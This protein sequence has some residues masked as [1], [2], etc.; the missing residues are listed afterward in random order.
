MANLIS[1]VS[2]ALST[3]ATWQVAD[4]TSFLQT[5]TNTQTSSATFTSSSAFTTGVITIDAIGLYLST[6]SAA[7]SGTF[8]VRLFNATLGAAVAGTTVTVNVTDIDNATTNG[9]GWYCFKFSAP[10]LLLTATSYTVQIMSSTSS[11]VTM[12]RDATANN[13]CRFL[14]T[15]TTQVPAAADNLLVMGNYTGA[16]T[17]SSIVVT[18]D[19]TA[20][21]FYG[22]VEI[23][24]NGTLSSAVVASTAYTLKPAGNILVWSNGTLNLGTSGSPMPASSSLTV[25]FQCTS[26]VQFGL[27]INSGGI[28]NSFGAAM[29][30]DRAK[31]AV[32]SIVGATSL[33]LNTATNWKNG[34]LL[35][36]AST[37]VTIAQSEWGTMGADASGTSI[38][39]ITVTGGGGFAFAH[40]GTGAIAAEVINLS[41][42]IKIKG[43]APLLIDSA[44][45]NILN[46]A[47]V[48]VQWTEFLILGSA[49]TLKTGIDVGTTTGSCVFSNCSIHHSNNASSMGIRINAAAGNNITITNNVFFSI[50]A[51]HIQNQATATTGLAQIISGNIAMLNGTGAIFSISNC[52]ITLQN[53]TAV[54]ATSN[55]FTLSDLT[56]D[57][58]GV[59][60][61]N[62]AHSNGTL[63]VSLINLVAISG[64]PADGFGTFTVWRNQ[65]YG[66]A[67]SACTGLVISGV[68][69]FGNQLANTGSNGPSA[70]IYWK[71][72]TADAG[73]IQIAT[74]GYGVAAYSSYIFLDNCTF[75][76][77]NT[78]ATGD[79]SYI[80]ASEFGEIYTRNTSLLSPNTVGQQ[81]NML[82]NSMVRI[83]RLNTTAGNHET[84]K[85]FG[86]INIDTVIVNSGT[87]STRMTPNSALVKLESGP[88]KFDIGNG[89]VATITAYVRKSVAG[90]GTAYNG[91]QPRLIQKANPALGLNNDVVLATADNTFNGA[92]KVLSGVITAPTDDGVIECVIDCDGTLGWINIDDTSISGIPQFYNAGSQNFWDNGLP[93]STLPPPVATARIDNRGLIV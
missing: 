36:L 51:N 28:W 11:Q 37:T 60:S 20:G 4:S 38:P 85:K 72:V 87:K 12:Y 5:Q 13:V 48:N 47:V 43:V 30:T 23:S 56:Y 65:T 54:S 41:R 24:K 52:K 93:A 1:A 55:G 31:L 15:T 91:S 83:Q 68:T 16:A 50:A 53:N 34:D 46:S 78:H 6:R 82:W 14:R 81:A 33:T 88:I 70:W 57:G 67:T 26:P 74:V 25:E 76:S 71:N 61:G 73:T 21:T 27:T 9:L 80:V 29:T 19:N 63:G 64:V 22:N 42:N 44:Y 75:G 84:F 3:A 32:D 92:F 17:G 2:G 69:A 18:M 59:M 66:I 58:T 77:T 35:G 49:T 86:K 79:I 90:D 45:V 89:Q 10:V 40:S 7:P 39:S 8:S 62:V